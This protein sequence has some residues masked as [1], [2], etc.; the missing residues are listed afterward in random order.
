MKKTMVLLL[1]MLLG[2]SLA[3]CGRDDDPEVTETPD[4]TATPEATPTPDPTVYDADE[5]MA[6][7][8]E[9]D[10]VLKPALDHANFPSEY[11]GASIT[12]QSSD[13]SII[14]HSG[15]VLDRPGYDETSWVV[16]FDITLVHHGD[17]LEET[18][19]ITVASLDLIWETIESWFAEPITGHLPLGG[20]T[21]VFD[22]EWES[23]NP[24]V[25]TPNGIVN[26]PLHTGEDVNVTMSVTMSYGDDDEREYTFEAV[27][28]KRHPASVVETVS[29]PFIS[30][31]YEWPVEARDVDIHYT[32]KGGMPYVDLM[33]FFA[34]LDAGDYYWDEDTGEPEEDMSEG[35]IILENIDITIDGSVVLLEYHHIPDEEDDDDEEFYAYMEL[36]F[37]NNTAIV[38]EYLFFSAFRAPTK[39]DFGEGLEV[40]D[41]M[42]E[43][44]EDA[45]DFNLSAYHI[46][47]FE[48]DG[49]FLL[50]FHLANLWFS[51][52]MYDVYY[53]GDALHGFDTYQRSDDDVQ[54][55]ILDSS[56]N[57]TDIPAQML[58]DSYNYTV[59]S[60]DHFYGMK[61]D[62]GIETFYDELS[63]DA[64]TQPGSANY[65]VL[66]DLIAS[67]DDLHTSF[68]MSGF[69]RR[70]HTPS[71][72]IEQPRL[73][74][75]IS[76]LQ[77]TTSSSIYGMYFNYD[78]NEYNDALIFNNPIHL[79]YLDD[80]NRIAR[81]RI[82]G[83]DDSTPDAF[84][85]VLD[86][87]DAM[88]TVED[89]VVDIGANLG[90]IVGT[91]WQVVAY[92]TDDPI[93]SY[94]INPA[95]GARSATWY[96]SETEA[97]TEFNWYILTSP[98]TYSAGNMMASHAK[99]MGFATLIGQRSQGGA[100]SIRVNI[101]PT[102]AMVIMSSTNISTNSDF[103]STEFGIE[104]DYIL[105]FN[106]F[107]GRGHI[108]NLINE[109]RA[110]MEEE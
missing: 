42:Y 88:G 110:D 48:E 93:A 49:Q 36:D 108:R 58:V 60:F 22:T 39:T 103:E 91:M 64:F 80:D 16:D 54:S 57:N 82:Y 63:F 92:M 61:N 25:I 55:A 104:P 86:E 53:N 84:A 74:Q 10:Y 21:I 68:N 56:R 85:A 95:D 101:N 13:T 83:F 81:I 41:T 17:T 20:Q 19:S 79:D 35:A 37:E 46:E 15:A 109:I 38:S 94:S 98:V 69:Y 67:L 47:I 11:Y 32:H 70:G 1:L 2:F 77:S 28:A 65:D 26:Q 7:L 33:T 44:P 87:I 96:I 24:D 78:P 43:G 89:I 4:A 34:L 14:D 90:G 107:G 6:M 100:S 50:P 51:G 59:F 72:D 75:L 66:N 97:R 27:V 106:R 9:S 52:S 12:W 45:Y 102:G 62:Y 76:D 29:L 3:A 23:S 8:L 99:D 73:N 40:Y 71:S 105:E 30:H 5:I 31:G 18:V